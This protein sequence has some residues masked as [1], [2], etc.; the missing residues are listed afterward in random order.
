MTW[1][2][3]T[4]VWCWRSWILMK[5]QNRAGGW[6]PFGQVKLHHL[7]LVKNLHVLNMSFFFPSDFRRRF[8]SLLSYQFSSF[9]PSLALTILQNKKATE[10]HGKSL[11]PSHLEGFMCTKP[12]STRLWPSQL[13]VA[14]NWQHISPLMTWNGWSCIRGVWWTTTS[15]WIWSQ[16]W[17]ASFSSSSLVTCLSLLHSV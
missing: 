12:T 3:N 17:R 6:L 16:W 15:S 14:L 4:P 11:P 5:L 10:T 1:Q 8:L 2:A 7:T 9:P 13:S